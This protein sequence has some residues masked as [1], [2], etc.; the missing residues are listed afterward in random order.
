MQQEA[1]DQLTRIAD[2]THLINEEDPIAAAYIAFRAGMISGKRIERA[3][4]KK[5]QIKEC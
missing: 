1:I 3:K 4:K 2:V 5:R